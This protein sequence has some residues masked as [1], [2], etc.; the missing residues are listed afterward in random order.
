MTETAAANV[1][2][3][4][5]KLEGAIGELTQNVNKLA[6]AQERE[7]Q[8]NADL[9]RNV[10]RLIGSI[11]SHRSH[12]D[13][14]FDA[15]TRDQAQARAPKWGT[16]IGIGGLGLSA[17]LAVCSL[18]AWGLNMGQSHNTE[19]VTRLETLHDREVERN[20]QIERR[21]ASTEAVIELYKAG[22]LVN[23]QS[24]TPALKP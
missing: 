11:E 3:R 13:G 7:Q 24:Q 22:M 1:N 8:S 16:L 5:D 10:D 17:V 2:K 15:I 14:R 6:A 9:S 4:V 19:R 23:P 18:F 12:V 20:N 21:L